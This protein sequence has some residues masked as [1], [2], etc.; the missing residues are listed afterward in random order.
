M[1]TEKAELET[2]PI[3]PEAVGTAEAPPAGA[4]QGP[5]GLPVYTEP[6][7][8][9][10]LVC[11]YWRGGNAAISECRRHGITANKDV[12]GQIIPGENTLVQ[13]L[14]LGTVAADVRS[15][16]VCE[17]GQATF[18]HV[19]SA[20]GAGQCPERHLIIGNPFEVHDALRE[21]A[22]MGAEALSKQSQAVHNVLLKHT[23]PR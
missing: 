14:R 13:D 18:C 5:T 11:K 12:H 19:K 20:L 1:A 10:P 4:V 6:A 3:P 17:R 9:L 22:A 7:L 2:K 21:L 8:E 15:L 23:R 16:G